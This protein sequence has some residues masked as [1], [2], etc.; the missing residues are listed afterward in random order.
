[1]TDADAESTDPAYLVWRDEKVTAAL[2]EAQAHPEQRFPQSEV[3][4]KYGLES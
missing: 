2:A 3:W 1:M 4:K